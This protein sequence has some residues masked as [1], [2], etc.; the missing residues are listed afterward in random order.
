MPLCCLFETAKRHSFQE[1]S[2]PLLVKKSAGG[3][4]LDTKGRCDSL[5]FLI[6]INKKSVH[7]PTCGA[8]IYNSLA[9]VFGL[10]AFLFPVIFP[11]SIFFSFLFSFL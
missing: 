8:N 2:S 4:G 11:L 7:A 10:A 3:L 5:S 9:A 6:A 1:I